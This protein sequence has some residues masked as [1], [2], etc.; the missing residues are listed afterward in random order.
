LLVGSKIDLRNDEKI[1]KKL[2]NRDEKPITKE[3]G[4]SVAEEIG[5]NNLYLLKNRCNRLF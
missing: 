1:L 5:N 3:E 2:K 4:L